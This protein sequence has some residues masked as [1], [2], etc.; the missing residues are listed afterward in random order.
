MEKHCTHE[1]FGT[2]GR[3]NSLG[4]KA[5]LLSVSSNCMNSILTSSPGHPFSNYCFLKRCFLKT[6][7]PYRKKNFKNGAQQLKD[8]EYLKCDKLKLCLNV[9]FSATHRILRKKYIVS[10]PASSPQ[11]EQKTIL[12]VKIKVLNAIHRNHRIIQLGQISGVF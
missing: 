6:L 3:T 7:L 5:V 2:A 12:K 11:R 8:M 10:A 1:C 9:I 4:W